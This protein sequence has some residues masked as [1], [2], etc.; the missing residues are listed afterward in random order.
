MRKRERKGEGT[1]SRHVEFFVLELPCTEM[2]L[3]KGE[4]TRSRHME[5]FVLELPCTKMG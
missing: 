2:G 3:W 5:L 4:G 1:R